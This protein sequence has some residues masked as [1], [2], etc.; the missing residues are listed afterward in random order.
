MSV[1]IAIAAAALVGLASGASAQRERPDQER[2][3]VLGRVVECRAIAAP[4]ERLACFDRAVAALDAAQTSGQLVAMDRQQVRRT[5]RSL[6]GLGLPDLGIFGD[7]NEDE[8]QARQI[9]ST[10]RSASQNAVGKWIITLADGARWLQTDSR[11]LNIE[12]RQGHPVRIRRAA[13]GSYLANV[14]GQ[15]AIRVRRIG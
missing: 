8:E 10:I 5:R 11:N 14:N 12:P 2:P 7:D 9:E 1:R 13:R 15:V 4:E 6:F 3:E